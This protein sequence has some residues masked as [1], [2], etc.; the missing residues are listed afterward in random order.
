MSHI[1]AIVYRGEV[2]DYGH[3]AEHGVDVYADKNKIEFGG[4]CE[5]DGLLETA[6]Y[7]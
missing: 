7:E 4:G 1:D 5:F 3:L 6:P 2:E